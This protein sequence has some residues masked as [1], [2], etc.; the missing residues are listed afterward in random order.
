MDHYITAISSST[1]YDFDLTASYATNFQERYAADS[2]IDGVFSRLLEI[3]GN[4]CLLEI[5]SVSEMNAPEL[6]LV[7][8]GD[9]L[10]DTIISE[11]KRQASRL[12]GVDQDLKPFYLMAGKEPFLNELI[13][14]F[15]GLHIPQAAS[16]WEG[17]VSAILGQQI[18]AHVAKL[19]RMNLVRTYGTALTDNDLTHYTFPGP[20]VIA[21]IGVVGLQAIKISKNKAKYIVDIAEGIVSGRLDLEKLQK[22]SDKEIIDFLTSI[23]GI[24]SWTVSW[25]LIRAF[26]RPDAFPAGD[27]AL[28]RTLNDFL[29]KGD[30]PLTPTNAIKI[31]E[32]WSPFRSFVTT[33]L[34]AG[35]RSG[36]F[37]EPGTP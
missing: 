1:P 13:C 14:R 5:S 19:L 23:R 33:Y 9:N 15:K 31:S 6:R 20:E 25:L 18:S 17:L 16:V 12:L 26:G 24:G 8:K 34:F 37:S 22:L 21:K 4:R 2:Y 28:R 32:R 36:L 30:S 11:A 10:D 7:I 35:V 27:L 29:I 3:R